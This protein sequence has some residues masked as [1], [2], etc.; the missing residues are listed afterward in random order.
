MKIILSFLLLLF[1]SIANAQDSTQLRKLDSLHY[2]SP[3]FRMYPVI[4]NNGL[5]LKKGEAKDLFSKAPGSFGHYKKYINRHKAGFYSFAGMFAGL[6]ASSIGFE[7]NNKG[8][9]AAG[10]TAAI[11]SLYSTF[12][13]FI[14]SDAQLRKAIK[15]Y[16]N[17]VRF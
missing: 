3:F 1:S 17:Q 5:T 11:A 15:L 14:S 7:N 4:Y 13:F 9:A 10:L 6:T 2:K 12:Y 8:L 16:N